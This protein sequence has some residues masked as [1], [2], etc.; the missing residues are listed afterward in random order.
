MAGRSFIFYTCEGE[1]G[2]VKVGRR[3]S[4]PHHRLV[5]VFVMQQNATKNAELDVLW[6]FRT[7]TADC[8][9]VVSV[10]TCEQTAWI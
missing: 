3:K 1:G 7:G 6:Q 9:V 4:V 5:L 8:C 10:V 2:G